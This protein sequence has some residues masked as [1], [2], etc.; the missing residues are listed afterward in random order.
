MLA[1]KTVSLVAVIAIFLSNIPEGLSS[2]AGMK[3]A[4]RPMAYVFGVWGGI[5]FLNGAAAALGNVVFVGFSEQVIAATMAFAAGA[6]LAMLVDT[7]IPEA[8]EIA[9][10]YAGMIAV[11]GF[12]AAFYLSKVSG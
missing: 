5:A 10:N 11:L 6:I 4:G 9:R 7:M 1:S 8:F 2:A 3:K 12:L